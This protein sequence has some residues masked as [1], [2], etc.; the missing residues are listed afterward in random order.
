MKLKFFI[1]FTVSLVM[2]ALVLRLVNFH[3]LKIQLL[4]ISLPT[5]LFI[6]LWYVAGQCTSA[7][8]WCCI[9]RA[10]GIDVPYST[11]LKAYFMGM[12]VNCY[13]LG[14]VGGDLARG[15]LLAEGQPRKAEAV[16]SVIADRVHG[17]TVLALLGSI[18]AAVCVLSGVYTQQPFFLYLL[19][20][21]GLGMACG[22][23]AGPAVLLRLLPAGS[24]F[25]ERAREILAVFPKNPRQLAF[26]S[27]ISVTFHLTQIFLHW[28]VA[29]Q[30]GA[31]IS[32]EYLFVAVPLVNII[33][34]L[35]ISWNGLGVREN[36]YNYFLV[37]AVMTSTQA[38]GLGAVWFLSVIVCSA[39]GGLIA[40]ITG[41]FE[42]VLRKRITDEA[43]E[44]SSKREATTST[45]SE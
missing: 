4:S 18:G 21:L 23:F 24:R 32:L 8:K 11:A 39:V 3:A 35:P 28:F 37:P 33:S 40:F 5:L 26:I 13:G 16:T 1:K 15:L 10:G 31:S 9:A 44:E 12:F 22:W 30:L 14:V 20:L 41:D 2:L 38:V 6:F 42:A 25:H 45:P 36:S 19:L 34:T 29:F 17:L 43:E 27:L 7:Y